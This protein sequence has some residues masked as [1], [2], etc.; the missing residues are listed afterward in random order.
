MN[1]SGR[2]DNDTQLDSLP[3]QPYQY[4]LLPFVRACMTLSLEEG[5][6]R[7]LLQSVESGLSSGQDR[8]MLRNGFRKPVIS[9]SLAPTIL[10]KLNTESFNI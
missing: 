9:V 10:G 6:S 7:D 4:S 1:I 8:L 5:W 2:T 3:Y